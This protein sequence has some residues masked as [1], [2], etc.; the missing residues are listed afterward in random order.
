MV[1]IKSRFHLFLLLKKRALKVPY[2]FMR[3]NAVIL[4]LG[5]YVELMEKKKMF[6]KQKIE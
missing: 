6:Q 1:G 3:K 5:C 2:I 4:P